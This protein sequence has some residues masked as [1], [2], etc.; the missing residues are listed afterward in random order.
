RAEGY[1]LYLEKGRVQ[2]NLSKR[3]L[4]DALRVETESRVAPDHWQH[5]MATYDGSR[6]AGGI[7]IYIDGKPQKLRILL[8]DLNQ[9]FKTGE[10]FRIGSLGGAEGCFTGYV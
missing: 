10:P 7:Q 6:V 8:D 1:S 3:W 9:D 2:L 4:D 5:V